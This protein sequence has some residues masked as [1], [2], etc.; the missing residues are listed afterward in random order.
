MNAKILLSPMVMK[1]TVA[2]FAIGGIFA[3]LKFD[4]NAAK[5]DAADAKKSLEQINSRLD[6]MVNASAVTTANLVSQDSAQVARITST[7]NEVRGLKD[8]N[9]NVVKALSDIQMD[10]MRSRLEAAKAMGDLGADIREIKTTL[11]SKP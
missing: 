11:R 8:A 9:A 7:E 10:A 5:G 4:T 6:A 3:L 2:V 1:W